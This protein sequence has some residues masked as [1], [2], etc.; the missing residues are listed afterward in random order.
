[1]GTDHRSKAKRAVST[2]W[3]PVLKYVTCKGTDR[4]KKICEVLLTPLK[5][6]GIQDFLLE[7]FCW[8]GLKPVEA[9]EGG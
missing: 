4:Y 2:Y 1:M 7:V 8:I 6:G 5:D 9:R 3:G